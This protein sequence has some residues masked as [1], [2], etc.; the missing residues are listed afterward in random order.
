MAAFLL[1]IAPFFAHANA[2]KCSIGRLGNR[3]APSQMYKNCTK[4]LNGELPILKPDIIV[5]QGDRAADVV[6]GDCKERVIAKNVG[7]KRVLCIRTYHPSNYRRFWKDGIADGRRWEVY[8]DAAA[9]FMSKR[10]QS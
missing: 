1:G 2:V 8:I 5:T 6:F 3:Q 4:F 9:D 7:E 10:R